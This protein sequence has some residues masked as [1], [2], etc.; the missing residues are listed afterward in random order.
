LKKLI[1]ILVILM[2]TLL[3]AQIEVNGDNAVLDD[4]VKE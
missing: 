2:P 1:L 3:F 4:Q